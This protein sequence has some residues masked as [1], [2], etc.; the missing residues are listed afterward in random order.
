MRSTHQRGISE[1]DDDVGIKVIRVAALDG[2]DA[3]GV[4]RQWG[5]SN[6]CGR[7]ARP[8]DSESGP[9]TSATHGIELRDLFLHQ[10]CHLRNAWMVTLP[11]MSKT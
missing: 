8:E 7:K 9:G 1:G 4:S 5:H 2:P 10:V 6:L 3:C 11:F